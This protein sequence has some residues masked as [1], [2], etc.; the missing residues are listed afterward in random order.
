MAEKLQESEV[1][2]RLKELSGWN[3]EKGELEREFTFKNFAEAMKFVN[4]VAERAEAAN[5]HPD[6]DIRWNKVRLRL[7]THS[8]GGLT[9]LDFALAAEIDSL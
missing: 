6:I 1:A 4:A 8:K 2:A 3:L 9:D 7:S 5:H